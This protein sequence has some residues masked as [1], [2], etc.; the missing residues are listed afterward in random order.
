MKKI[1]LISLLS[2]VAF[3]S[4]AQKVVVGPIQGGGGNNGLSSYEGT[5]G[6]AVSTNS[7]RIVIDG[8]GIAAGTTPAYAITNNQTGVTFTNKAATRL[9]AGVTVTSLPSNSIPRFSGNRML[10]NAANARF[11]ETTDSVSNI[12]A[13]TA[14]GTN[15]LLGVGEH[16]VI[17]AIVPRGVS[18]SGMGIEQTRVTDGYTA[19]LANFLL[20]DN[21]SLNNLY[22]VGAQPVT[23]F[24]NHTTNVFIRNSDLRGITDAIQFNSH[25]TGQVL[26]VTDTRIESAWDQVLLGGTNVDARYTFERVA[27]YGDLL[28]D[29]AFASNA[30][31]VLTGFVISSGGSFDFNNIFMV[32][33]NAL[34]SSFFTILESPKTIRLR[35]ASSSYFTAVTNGGV[36]DP[37]SI[38]NG[39]TNTFIE[40]IDMPLFSLTTNATTYTNTHGPQSTKLTATG[41]RTLYLPQIG[42]GG[43]TRFPGM[44]QEVVDV[45]GTAATGNITITPQGGATIDGAA[46][47][48]INQNLGSVML[49]VVGTNWVSS[50]VNKPM[51]TSSGIASSVGGSGAIQFAEGSALGGT[52]K[53]V[54]DRTNGTVKFVHPQ[55]IV[56]GAAGISSRPYIE[57]SDDAGGS[58][59]RWTVQGIGNISL[60]STFSLISSG[61]NRWQVDEQGDFIPWTSRLQDI[62]SSGGLIKD[63]Y[64]VNSRIENVMANVYSNQCL[65]ILGAASV[66]TIYGTNQLWKAYI[67]SNITFAD[68]ALVSNVNYFVKSTNNASTVAYPGT[69]RWWSGNS[70][71]AAPALTGGSYE[72]KVW[73]DDTGTNASLLIGP[74]YVLVAGYKTELITNATLGTVTA[75]T[76]Q[77][78]TNYPTGAFTINLATDV[79]VNVTNAVAS[80]YA[81]T[82]ATPVIGTSGSIGLVSDG[83]ARTL[84]F[85]CTAA[86]MT[87][88][89]TND[90]ANSTNLLTTASK[91]SLVAWRVGMATD[92]VTTNIHLWAK[93]QSP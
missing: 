33:S 71:T 84:S 47:L 90:L 14:P 80:N 73:K 12:V 28:L 11:A 65:P 76:T 58:S 30:D 40:Y 44:E 92:G 86:T 46:T 16:S 25:G 75:Q 70:M 72:F 91:R 24:T 5:G 36:I 50:A 60:G 83:S 56:G 77:R 1:L 9:E 85:L 82:L 31:R 42:Y 64:G 74:E 21:S 41:A 55:S 34:R 29:S 17:D 35:I 4:Y 38:P 7:N 48:V 54:V 59:N 51:A 53:F 43:L 22:V 6:I 15:V 87:W 63:Y 68:S 45:A 13:R 89:S 27:L 32:H 78:Y 19:L 49:R 69:W 62:G 81:I 18:I 57:I 23:L 37:F 61:T 8:S 66:V 52:N 79:T 10:T 20:N 88:M 67:T 93:N 39:A 3:S 2:L 26:T